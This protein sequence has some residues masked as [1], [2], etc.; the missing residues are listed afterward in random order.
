MIFLE[1]TPTGFTY[2]GSD[3]NYYCAI[4]N[5]DCGVATEVYPMM[6]GPW[7]FSDPEIPFW[8]L[9]PLTGGLLTDVLTY[10]IM[11]MLL[12]LAIMGAFAA[13]CWIISW[14]FPR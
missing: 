13:Y 7:E 11:D 10:Y 5:D 1:E 6:L 12:Y 2:I 14:Y 9:S 8:S 4:S 3:N